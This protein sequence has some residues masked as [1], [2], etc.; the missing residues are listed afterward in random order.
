MVEPG[1]AASN[2]NPMIEQAETEISLRETVNCDWKPSASLQSFAAARAC[3]PSAPEP[4]TFYV[5][6]VFRAWRS[7]QLDE[8]DWQ[9]VTEATLTEVLDPDERLDDDELRERVAQLWAGPPIIGRE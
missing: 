1:T 3:R 2:I 4:A 8:L 5:E 9:W 7:R 6:G